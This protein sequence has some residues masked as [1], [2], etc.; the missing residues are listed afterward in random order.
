[1]KGNAVKRL[2]GGRFRKPPSPALLA[3]SNAGALHERLITHDIA[4]SRAHAEALRE[5]G[6]LDADEHATLLRALNTIALDVSRGKD[7]PQDFDEDIHTFLERALIE[8]LGPLGA[9]LRAG[10]S[11]N[12]QAANDLKAYLRHEAC[13]IGAELATLARALARRAEE[14]HADPCPGFTH[15]QI[16]QPVTFGHLLMAHAQ[17]LARNLERLIDFRRRSGECPLGAAALAGTRFPGDGMRM[18][19][20]LGYDGPAENSMDAVGARDHVV[21]FLFISAMIATDLSR[22]SEEITL[23]TSRQFGWV[24]LD[25]GYATGSSIMPQKK[26]PDIAEIT[27][28]RASRLIGGLV[29]MMTA[30]KG[31]PLTYNRDLAEDKRA[32]FDAVDVIHVVL[33]AMTGLIETMVV[34][35]ERLLADADAGFALATEPADYLALKGVPFAEAHDIAGALVRRAEERGVELSGLSAADLAAIDPRL[36]A[37]CLALLTPQAAIAQR[38]GHGGTAPKRVL[39]QISRFSARLDGLMNGLSPRMTEN[40][41]V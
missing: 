9:K 23:W 20:A 33:P 36:D 39:E 1:M 8:R 22:L 18:A 15:L 34:R 5:A 3:I 24:E 41:H 12:D 40:S 26:N 35:T 27:R 14:F 19:Q 30:L 25:D 7:G 31:L 11:R 13:R 28:G 38:T 21:E 16:A 32:A 2:W 4:G 10:R 6:I 37:E 17:P 29:T